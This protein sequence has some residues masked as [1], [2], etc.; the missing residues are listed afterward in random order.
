M[1][2]ALSNSVLAFDGVRSMERAFL[3]VPFFKEG[4]SY[5]GG[6]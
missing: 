2:S 4:V 5:C 6:K 3:R 1:E